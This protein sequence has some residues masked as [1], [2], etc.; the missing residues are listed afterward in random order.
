MLLL[1]GLAGIAGS[2]LGGYGADRLGYRKNAVTMLVVL[3]FSLTAF[4][5]LAVVG[6]TFVTLG[7]RWRWRRWPSRASLS[8][9][10]SSTA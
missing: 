4:S 5:V 9:R 7:W 8:S 3:M 10:C 6:A 2:A 1:F